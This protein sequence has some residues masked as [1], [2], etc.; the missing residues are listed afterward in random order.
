MPRLFNV[1]IRDPL[2]IHRKNTPVTFALP[3]AGGTVVDPATIQVRDGSKSIPVQWSIAAQWQ[4]ASICW[5]HGRSLLE[6]EPGQQLD[7][8][9][10]LSEN[11]QDLDGSVLVTRDSKRWQP[12][13]TQLANLLAPGGP[14]DVRIVIVEKNGAVHQSCEPDQVE[15]EENGPLYASIFES[16]PLEDSHGQRKFIYERR[17]HLH[18]NTLGCH[19]EHTF[20]AVDGEPVS[21]L[22][23]VKLL[24]SGRGNVRSLITQVGDKDQQFVLNDNVFC[25][26][27]Q[28]VYEHEP[29]SG[30]PQIHNLEEVDFSYVVDAGSQ[31]EYGE[32]HPGQFIF[33][34][35]D[36]CWLLGVR[37]FWQ[38]GPKHVQ[39]DENGG[40]TI[41]LVPPGD[42]LK[43]GKTRAITHDIYMVA[44]ANAKDQLI[45]LMN[46]LVPWVDP[47]HVSR[48]GALPYVAPPKPGLFP[49]YESWFREG[50]DRWREK[51]AEYGILHHGDWRIGA[52]AYATFPSYFGDHEY[53]TMHSLLT[54]YVRTGQTEYFY[55]GALGARHYA[56]MDI[57]Q[58][59][60]QPRFHG[61][62]DRADRHV[63]AWEMDWGHIFVDGL[64]DH[65]VLT[66]DRRSLRAAVRVADLC[67]E[68]TCEPMKLL[69]GSE[70]DVGL[71]LLALVRVYELT[72]STKYLKAA[73]RLA[74]FIANFSLHP[75]RYLT[76]GTWWRTWMHES[77][78]F[79]LAMELLVAM[80]RY[81]DLTGDEQVRQA[82]IA[83]SNW[84]LEHNWDPERIGG[85]GQWNRYQRGHEFGRGHVAV[86]GANL[87][88]P[89]PMAL[90][91]KHSGDA[92]FMKVAW[93]VFSESLEANPP[94]DE[95]R[96]FTTSRFFSIHF[97][98]LAAALG[99]DAIK[100]LS[101]ET[102]EA[103]MDGS[104]KA[105]SAGQTVCA[106]VHG[107]AELVASPWGPVRA[108]LRCRLAVLP[109]A[110]RC[111]RAA[112]LDLVLVQVGRRLYKD[113]RSRE[114]SKAGDDLY[115]IGTAPGAG[116]YLF[117]QCLGAAHYLSDD[118]VK[119]V[120][121]ARMD[122]D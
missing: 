92:R 106:E 7:L 23:E 65:H 100:V 52:G 44:D 40:V 43:F 38:M 37:P 81:V 107:Q 28:C 4:D 66:G 2:E 22:A 9:V 89:L 118:L 39:V 27:Q 24:I 26:R 74:D 119:G 49:R 21:Q 59:T 45:D 64:V 75:K 53:D 85:I 61:Y 77:S 87:M 98:A 117:P 82:F 121:L 20:V 73:A 122:H 96:A 36:G 94:A 63:E 34:A 19:V 3:F 32:K 91:Y 84:Y 76:Q 8:Q 15:I 57:D 90:A 16:G 120:R 109:A 110:A 62:L 33:D 42:G 86:S 10:H 79:V 88:L 83:A 99:D 55:E 103:P 116:R 71:P 6:I 115:R 30:S 31:S 51:C 95:D 112:R 41:W 80:G 67:A 70:R 102:F 47:D 56:D 72:R 58:V 113:A 68:Q 97:L 25:L 111:A 1:A 78:Q 108:H 35:A 101:T 93:D 17:I 60:G 46:R 114:A 12:H 18:A 105:A 69:Q 29:E 48:T 11:P 50:F 54:Q 13:E 104:H 5:A 14:F